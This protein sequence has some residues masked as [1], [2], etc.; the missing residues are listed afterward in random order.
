MNVTGGGGED[1]AV[2]TV[3]VEKPAVLLEGSGEGVED[4]VASTVVVGKTAALFEE[5]S[6]ELLEATLL[7]LVPIGI[8]LVE[9]TVELA[10]QLWTPEEQDVTVVM[11]VLYIVIVTGPGAGLVVILLAEYPMIP[12]ANVVVC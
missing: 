3:V 9:T 2:S 12:G 8:K 10:G 5:I 6:I 11:S 1:D 7:I 4:V